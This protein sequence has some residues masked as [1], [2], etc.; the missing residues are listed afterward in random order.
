M[1]EL[2]IE[3]QQERWSLEAQVSFDANDDRAFPAVTDREMLSSDL[4]LGYAVLF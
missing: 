3:K 2:A 4:E 1:F